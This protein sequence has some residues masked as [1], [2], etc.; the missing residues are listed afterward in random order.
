MMRSAFWLIVTVLIAAPLDAQSETVLRG[1]FEGKT[2]VTKMDLPAT[3]EGV[4]VYP[5]AATPVDFSRYAN[6]LK[7]AGTAVKMGESIIVTKVR[8]RDSHI[9]FQ[10][11]G[12]GF[13]TFG[14]LTSSPHT[15]IPNASKTNREKNLERD[16]KNETDP[17][18]RRKIRE[19]LDDLRKERERENARN[20]AARASAEEAR[21]ANARQQALSSGSRFNI[22]Y[23][24]TLVASQLTPESVMQALGKYLDFSPQQFTQTAAGVVSGSAYRPASA[25]TGLGALRKGALRSEVEAALGQPL[26]S[27]ERSEG[28]LKVMTLTFRSDAGLVEAQFVEDVL[29]R[30]I[31]RSS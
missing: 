3:S 1:Y 29:I 16:L 13:G 20:A 24:S 23:R 7:E 19:E 21:R 22:R 12:G 25:P 11:G 27:S 8:V 14:D 17:A 2:V 18:K 9:E 30:Y 26:S 10:L 15:N 4:D 28:T 6:R 5:E 31:V